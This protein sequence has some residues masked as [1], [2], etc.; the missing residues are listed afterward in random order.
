MGGQFRSD[1][2]GRKHILGT[3]EAVRKQGASARFTGWLV[4]TGGKFCA[5]CTGE[6]DAAGGGWHN[7]T[8]LEKR[9]EQALA[10]SHA[11]LLTRKP[12]VGEHS[13]WGNEGALVLV[14][15][16]QRVQAGFFVRAQRHAAQHRQ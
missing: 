6:G 14:G 5:R 3:G 2:L 7:Q 9:P 15:L 13:V 4:E 1:A 10:R 16:K 8:V 12:R 11:A